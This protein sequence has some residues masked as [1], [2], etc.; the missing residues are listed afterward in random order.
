[1]SQPWDAEKIVTPELAATLIRA[2]FPA[3][4]VRRVEPLGQGWDNTAFLVDQSIV[5]RFPR[6]ASAVA[7]LETEARALPRLAPRLPVNIPVPEW[8]GRPADSFPWP[9]LG[10]RLV[11][12]EIAADANLSVTER[13][14]LA[15]ALAEFLARLHRIRDSAL[16]L[17]PDLLDR[18]NFTQ[19]RPLLEQRLQV[20]VDH[21]HIS[22]AAPWLEILRRTPESR[23]PRTPV[24]VHGDFY[25]CH[26][27]VDN[28]RRL[29]G[30]IDW[31][32]VHVGDPAIDLMALFG[33]LPAEARPE[34]LHV[35]G[36]IDQQ[37]RS[38]AR[39]RAAFHAVAVAWYGSQLN[40]QALLHEGLTAM[41]F[42]LQD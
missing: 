13:T 39:L 12:G 32:D 14:A 42:V 34:F 24:P 22:D 28:S 26:M 35:Y 38:T 7:L 25:A 15:P 36:P 29:L 5:F 33:F 2:Q 31:G 30:V 4:P 6:K 9:F 17:P 16:E 23:A 21:G 18:A 40:D 8:H 27:L 1:M 41:Q 20:L 37:T 19:R 11:P 10:H 3:L